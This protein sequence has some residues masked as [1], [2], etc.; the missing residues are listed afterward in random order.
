MAKMPEKWWTM[1]LIRTRVLSKIATTIRDRVVEPHNES[2]ERVVEL[3]VT[4]ISLSSKISFMSGHSMIEF[5]HLM[6]G[7]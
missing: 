4:Y 3:Q 6:R 1:M 2:M 5:I 7:L